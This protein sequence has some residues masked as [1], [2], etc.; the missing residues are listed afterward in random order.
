[1]TYQEPSP[2]VDSAVIRIDINNEGKLDEETEKLFFSIVKNGFSQRRKT[3]A[4][5]L[6]NKMN[7]SKDTVFNAFD[8]INAEKSVRIEQLT[9]EQ[10]KKLAYSIKNN[11]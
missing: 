9:M 7:I 11:P 4:N 6:T 8:D 3:L 10:L 1:M 2:N 5:A